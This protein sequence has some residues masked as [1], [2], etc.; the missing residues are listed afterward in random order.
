MN[1][2]SPDKSNFLFK[3]YHISNKLIF[4]GIITYLISNKINDNNIITNSLLYGN[5][6][7]IGFHSYV[8]TSSIISDYLKP[9]NISKLAR[10]S[11]FGLHSLAIY[12]LCK[13]IK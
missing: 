6:F 3:K 11:N 4:P 8:S 9:K 7:N 12:G 1:I 2:L 5:I 10:C 13:N